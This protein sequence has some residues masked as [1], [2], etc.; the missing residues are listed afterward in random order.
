M[1]MSVPMPMYMSGLLSFVLVLNALKR[2]A[3]EA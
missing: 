1:M 2:R 3:L